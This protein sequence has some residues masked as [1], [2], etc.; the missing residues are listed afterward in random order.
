MGMAAFNRK[1]REAAKLAKKLAA[2]AVQNDEVLVE[3]DNPEPETLV[4]PETVVEHEV[5][6]EATP[7][8]AADGETSDNHEKKTTRKRKPTAR[9]A[10]DE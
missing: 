6:S 9:A 5:L 8:T 2:E 4:E 1:R 3:N 10:S 7:E